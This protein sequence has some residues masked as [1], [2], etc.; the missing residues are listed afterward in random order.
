MIITVKRNT[1]DRPGQDITEPLLTNIP[2]MIERGRNEL[3]KGEPLQVVRL[4]CI[5][6]AG[7]STGD[8]VEV[9]DYSQGQPYRGKITSVEHVAANGELTTNLELVRL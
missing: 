6:I 8:L 9:Q 2:A 7:I 4:T 3:D 5:Y 1:A